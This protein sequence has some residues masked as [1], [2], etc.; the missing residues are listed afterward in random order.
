MSIVWLMVCYLSVSIL[1]LMVCQFS[2][3]ILRV[4][5]KPVVKVCM[6]QIMMLVVFMGHRKV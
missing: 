3:S 4:N 2:M 6:E 5:F 1:W